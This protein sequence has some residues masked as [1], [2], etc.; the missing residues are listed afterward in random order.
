MRT[1]SA[2]R[3]LEVGARDGRRSRSSGVA[4]RTSGRRS[5]R[6]IGVGVAQ[7]RAHVDQRRGELAHQRAAARARPAAARSASARA[8]CSARARR[9]ERAGQPLDRLPPAPPRGAPIVVERR[10][11]WP[12]PGSPARS[13]FVRPRRARARAGCGPAARSFARRSAIARVTRARAARAS[14]ACAS[15]SARRSGPRSLQ[16]A[17]PAFAKI[18]EVAAR[19]GVERGE[20]LVRVDVRRVSG[21]AGMRSPSSSRPPSSSRGVGRAGV[22]LDRHVVQ[23]GLRPQQH[24]SR[25]GRP[26]RA[27]R[28]RGPPSRRRSPSSSVDLRRSRPPRR[29]RRSRSG[30]GPA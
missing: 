3:R 25:C 1:R 17:P 30:P 12:R 5:S 7:Q 28:A 14:A 18:G 6:R 11:S 16:P 13:S 22:E 9:A 21:D 2:R 24:A 19:V 26:G 23:P 8:S 29:R 27:R 4:S 15:S 20:H 10:R